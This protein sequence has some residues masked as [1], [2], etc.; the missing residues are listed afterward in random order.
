VEPLPETREA[1]RDLAHLVAQLIPSCLGLSLSVPRTGVTLTMVATT[2]RAAVL[3]GVQYLDGG[4]CV[5]AIAEASEM[6]MADALDEDR[7]HRYAV[8]AA[9]G[10]VRSSLSIPVLDDGRATGAVNIYAADPHAFD[11]RV[12]AVRALVGRSAGVAVTDADLAFRTREVAREAPAILRDRELVDT[13]TGFVAA[14]HRVTV[15]EAERTLSDAARRAGIDV[16]TLARTVLL[17]QV[18][19]EDL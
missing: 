1:M 2:A 12:D 6:S 17:E 15:E 9:T 5:D 7:W 14:A 3:D 11:G 13:A 4:P 18:V 10:G 16:V 8:A 19:P